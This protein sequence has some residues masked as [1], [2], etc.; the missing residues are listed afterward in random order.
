MAPPEL[1]ADAPVLNVVEPMVVHFVPAFGV[2]AKIAFFGDFDGP[3]NA[4]I[5]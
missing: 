2:E 4:G 1:A 5:F 3:W